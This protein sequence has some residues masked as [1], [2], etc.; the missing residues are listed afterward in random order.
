MFGPGS[1]GNFIAGLLNKLIKKEYTALDISIGGSSHTVFPNRYDNGDSLSFG[2]IADEQ[3]EF[4]TQIERE[5]YY[6]QAINEEYTNME[7]PQVTWTHDFTNIPVYKKYFKNCRILTIT[8]DSYASRLSSVYMHVTKFFFNPDLIVPIKEPHRSNSLKNWEHR[9]KTELIP[10][11][12]ADKANDI[13][14]TRSSKQYANDIITYLSLRSMARYYGL[15][16]YSQGLPLS[17]PC[18]YDFALYKNKLYNQFPLVGVNYSEYIDRSDAIL[19]YSYLIDNR[20]ILL[21]N[22]VEKI[23]ERSLSAQEKEFILTE[24]IAYRQCQNHD[25]LTDPISYYR[26]MEKKALI[27]LLKL[28]K[29]Y[30]DVA[31]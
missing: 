27:H 19:S 5:N 2:K 23:L 28:K 29:D 22:S 20:P 30:S 7:F 3:V 25:I 21:I 13:F 9:C 24:Y 17:E 8:H 4:T 1:G 15:L 31:S 14:N 16:D 26:N 12:G 10:Y 6:I 18:R 11:V